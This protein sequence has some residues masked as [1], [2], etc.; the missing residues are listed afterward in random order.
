MV[1]TGSIEEWLEK[2]RE[3]MVALEARDWIDV[4]SGRRTERSSQLVIVWFKPFY[5]PGFIQLSRFLEGEWE[6]EK[7][8]GKTSGKVT[9]FMFLP[10]PPEQQEEDDAS[11]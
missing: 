3:R 9:H 8:M 2:H 1:R 5:G 4:N 6:L 7:V 11:N 10:D